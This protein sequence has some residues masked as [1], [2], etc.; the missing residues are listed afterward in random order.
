VH[1]FLPSLKLQPVADS[2]LPDAP[3]AAVISSGYQPVEPG[4]PTGGGGGQPPS[5]CPV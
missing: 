2:V 1:G 4:A 3:V 5:Q